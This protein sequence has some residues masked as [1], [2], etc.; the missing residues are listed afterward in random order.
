MI[1]R[2]RE[3]SDGWISERFSRSEPIYNLVDFYIVDSVNYILL[4]IQLVMYDFD[5][6]FCTFCKLCD[7]VRFCGILVCFVVRR[8]T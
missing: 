8:I 2:G 4:Y 7:F 3:A 5:V 6:Q 1:R